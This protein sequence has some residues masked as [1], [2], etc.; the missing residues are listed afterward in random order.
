MVGG[1]SI[2]FDGLLVDATAPPYLRRARKYV[3][4]STLKESLCF[5]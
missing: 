1:L 5:E 2:V 3:Q 4:G